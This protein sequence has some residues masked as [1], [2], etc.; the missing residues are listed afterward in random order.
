ML[1]PGTAL[2]DKVFERMETKLMLCAHTHEAF[3]IEKDGKTIVNGGSLGLPCGGDNAAAFAVIEF[4]FGRW[5]PTLMRVNYDVEAVVRE[6]RESGF[7]QR[8]HVWARAMAKTICT[9]R[10]FTMECIGLVEQY[11]KEE[12]L[13][14]HTEDLWQR[15][16]AKLGI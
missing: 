13:P 2:A 5:Q 9:G 3:I 15:A 1:L 4:A 8:G 12:G 6:F 16:A 14:F 11:S 10:D 7:M